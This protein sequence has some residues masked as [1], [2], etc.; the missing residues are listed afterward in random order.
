MILWVCVVCVIF[1]WLSS[2]VSFFIKANQKREERKHLSFSSSTIMN[3]FAIK[4]ITFSQEPKRKSIF[5]VLLTY[6]LKRLVVFSKSQIKVLLLHVFLVISHVKVGF[7][8]S[9]K[10]GFL[11]RHLSYS[12]HEMLR[13]CL[14]IFLFFEGIF[15]N[16]LIYFW[17]TPVKLLLDFHIWLRKG[18]KSTCFW[19]KNK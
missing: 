5:D 1:F 14:Q 11:K 17:I 10:E 9:K 3:W 8:S 18:V 2:L 16:D 19:H 13:F 12:C 4:T 15:K 7:V 6:F